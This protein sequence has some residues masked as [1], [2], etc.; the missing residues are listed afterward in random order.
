MLKAKRE[1]NSEIEQENLRLCVIKL[2]AKVDPQ[3]GISMHLSATFHL[4]STELQG[5]MGFPNLFAF[6]SAMLANKARRIFTQPWR[7]GCAVYL[8]S[9]IASRHQLVHRVRDLIIKCV[10]QRDED[11]V[12][13]L[14]DEQSAISDF[15]TPK[16]PSV[17]ED[18]LM[19]WP[20]PKSTFTVKN[21]TDNNST[22]LRMSPAKMY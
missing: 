21:Q 7:G 16:I 13:G 20:D 18:R 8:E 4:D 14:F 9:L 3:I 10:K 15:N 5:G 2:L 1:G 11:L 22:S 6:H 19:W 17:I 12:H